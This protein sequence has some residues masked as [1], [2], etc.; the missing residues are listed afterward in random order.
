MTH[1]SLLLSGVLAL[2]IIL[3]A[4][5]TT[6]LPE[7]EQDATSVS[8]AR[9]AT[10]EVLLT[11]GA[12]IPT[13]TPTVT[14]SPTIDVPATEMALQATADFEATIAAEAQATADAELEAT[15][16]Q[17]TVDAQA[18]INAQPTEVGADD[19]LF[20][21]IQNANASNG[22]LLFTAIEGGS[23]CTTCHSLDPEV[24]IVGPSQYNLFART[25]ERLAD[26]TI[27]D[28]GPYSYIYNSVVHPNDYIVE[29]DPPY[30]PGVM[31]QNYGELLT[32]EELY[33]LVAYMVQIGD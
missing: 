15:N 10:R 7:Y 30:A 19:P 22:E 2:S 11:Q 16:A 1:K 32:E 27:E 5:G 24:R 18:T 25:V 28:D 20:E 23:P 26:G 29:A 12:I 13:D 17:A 6:A 9:T 33:D 4:C 31:P 8:L 21:A 14:P 3:T